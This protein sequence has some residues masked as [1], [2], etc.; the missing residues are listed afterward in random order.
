[1]R[2]CDGQDGRVVAQEFDEQFRLLEEIRGNLA[3]WTGEESDPR[4]FSGH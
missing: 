4:C 2:Y 3:E 1:V